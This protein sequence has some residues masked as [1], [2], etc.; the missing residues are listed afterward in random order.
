VTVVVYTQ[1]A[2]NNAAMLFLG[3]P[4]GFFASGSFPAWAHS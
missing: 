2:I 1:L 3:F 4:L